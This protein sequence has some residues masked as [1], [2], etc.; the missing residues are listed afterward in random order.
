MELEL[1]RDPT[2]DGCTLGSLSINGI[3]ECYSLEP[4]LTGPA[5][6]AIPALIYPV[7]LGWSAHFQ[8]IV[9]HITNVPGREEIEIHWGNYVTNTKGCILWASKRTKR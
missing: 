5:P 6:V 1:F 8:R 2:K 3:F 4:P 7:T 9:P